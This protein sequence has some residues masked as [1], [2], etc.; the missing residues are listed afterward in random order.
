MPSSKPATRY[1]DILDNIAKISLY[2][3]GYDRQMFSADEKT[4]DAVERCL[5]RISEAAVKLGPI[6]E[7]D[8]PM[9]PWR[10]VRGLGNHLRHAY[11]GVDADILWNLIQKDLKALA[12]ACQTLLEKEHK[13]CS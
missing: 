2:V 13:A 6:A 11:D 12:D 4:I 10:E 3:D 5:S 9:I 8:A 1:R 7:V